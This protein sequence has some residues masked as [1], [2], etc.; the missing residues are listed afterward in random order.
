V[1]YVILWA[2]FFAGAFYEEGKFVSSKENL[3]KK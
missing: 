1:W 2:L 3:E